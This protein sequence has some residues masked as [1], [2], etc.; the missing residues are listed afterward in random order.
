MDT[1]THAISV[2]VIFSIPPDGY[3]LPFAVLGA[4]IPDV[5]VVYGAISRR[6]PG[7]YLLTHGGFTH[8]I[9]G[10]LALSALAFLVAYSL[11]LSG[12]VP[13]I[14]PG[15]FGA[16]A[17]A[18]MLAGTLLHVLEDFLAY[19]GIPLL[20]PLT[21]RKFTAGIF[22]GPSLVLFAVSLVFVTWAAMGI[23][24]PAALVWYAAIFFSF[25]GL[26]AAVKGYIAL[27]QKGQTIPTFNP[28][29]WIL[30]EEDGPLLHIRDHHLLWGTTATMTVDRFRGITPAEAARYADLPGVREHRYFS[31]LSVAERNGDAVTFS[32]P[33]RHGGVLPYPTYARS[34]TVPREPGT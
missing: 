27:T 3:L 5:D 23:A 10:G 4:I 16:A 2:L 19:P 1:F 28:L 13:W 26:S 15:L 29:R 30:L 25:I 6:I 32:D 21:E 14:R 8:S 18:A 31:Y 22:P 20:Y 12:L 11:A 7:L 17:L 33:L 24:G 9:A 34:V